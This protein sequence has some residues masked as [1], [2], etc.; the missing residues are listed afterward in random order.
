[1]NVHT[2]KMQELEK[3]IKSL[4]PSAGTAKLAGDYFH[5]KP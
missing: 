1:M 3:E 2:K 5:A 4:L